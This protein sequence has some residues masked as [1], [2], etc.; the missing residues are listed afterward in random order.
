M[1]TNVSCLFI[2]LSHTIKSLQVIPTFLLVW[3]NSLCLLLLII[4]LFFASLNLNQGPLVGDEPCLPI[5]DVSLNV[6]SS[7]ID[8]VAVNAA[9][10]CFS[11][12]LLLAFFDC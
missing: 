8:D 11:V 7:K 1:R 4:A 2:F 10:V 6:S 12:H 5:G 9:K 3:F